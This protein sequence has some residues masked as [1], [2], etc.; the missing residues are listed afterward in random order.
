MPTYSTSSRCP[1]NRYTPGVRGRL[2]VNLSLAACGWPAIE[3]SVVRSSRPSTPRP[4]ARSRRRCSR[5]VVASASSSARW[6]GRWSSR[7]RDASVP[8]RQ[9]GTS[10]RTR[11]RARATVS[12]LTGSKRGCP[13]RSKAARRN[14]TSKPMLWPTMTVPRVNSR[15]DGRT[16]SIRGAGP[17]SASVR[18]VSTVICGGMARPGL[19]RVWN[20]PRHSPPRTFTAPTSVIASSARWPPVVSRSSTQ[21][22]TSASGVPRSSKLRWTG[23]PTASMRPRTPVR[24]KHQFDAGRSASARRCSGDGRVRARPSRRRGD[25]HGRHDGPPV[26]GRGAGRARRRH[27]W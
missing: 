4:A 27:R 17:T 14:A 24:V 6:V 3:A 19:T 21:N 8:S 12:T 26:G 11:R 25:L 10:S 5:S 13:A 1:Q 16:A 20:V 15:S 22:V 23:R 7:N 2:E 9:S 18:P